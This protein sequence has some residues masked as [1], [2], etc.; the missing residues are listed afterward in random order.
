MFI[1]KPAYS[2]V[3]KEYKKL[4]PESVIELMYEGTDKQGI[5]VVPDHPY[6]IE[7]GMEGY[8][9]LKCNMEWTKKDRDEVIEEFK[10]L[11][12][13]ISRIAKVYY[14]LS[15]IMGENRELLSEEDF[16]VWKKYLRDL[17]NGHFEKDIERSIYRL[18]DNEIYPD[19]KSD[20]RYMRKKSK[21]LI[22]RWPILEDEEIFLYWRNVQSLRDN[23]RRVFGYHK[24]AFDLCIRMKRL[25][26]LMAFGAPQSLIKREAK[27]LAKYMV[28][29][30]Y[31]I[32]AEHLETEYGIG[33]PLANLKN[34]QAVIHILTTQ[35]IYEWSSDDI[36]DPESIFFDTIY[37]S[38]AELGE[39]ILEAFDV[40]RPFRFDSPYEI[41]Q[42]FFNG[43]KEVGLDS[44]DAKVEC[45]DPLEDDPGFIIRPDQE[46]TREGRVKRKTTEEETK[47][48]LKKVANYLG[49]DKKTIKQY[50][51]QTRLR[52]IKS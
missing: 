47:S 10:T 35:P 23:I 21:H 48:I 18:I 34:P 11:Y 33:L 43:N 12:K 50:T 39:E 37:Y 42:D 31:C 52:P 3:D 26:Y 44:G 36:N 24:F 38:E 25:Y 45:Y 27:R 29:R 51:I 41:L 46:W 32:E 5:L 16:E 15:D 17:E 8:T 40:E 30:K 9:W 28:L 7:A 49:A 20:A 22:D 1:V 4:S 13:S 6:E 14:D 19:R 2:I